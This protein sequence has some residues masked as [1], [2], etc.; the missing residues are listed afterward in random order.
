MERKYLIKDLENILKICRKT[1]Y[2]WERSGKVPKA[3][4]DPMSNY[5]YWLGR[6]IKELKKITQR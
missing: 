5:R 6:D 3:R 4:R 1:Y 2:N